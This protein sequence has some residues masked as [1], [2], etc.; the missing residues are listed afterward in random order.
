[1][2]AE[3]WQGQGRCSVSDGIPAF[4]GGASCGATET[5]FLQRTLVEERPEVVKYLTGALNGAMV[6]PTLKSFPKSRI[7]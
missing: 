4:V 5:A 1:M 7:I 3:T 6:T 2:I